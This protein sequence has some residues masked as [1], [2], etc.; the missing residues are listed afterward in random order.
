VAHRRAPACSSTAASTRRSP[1]TTPW[2]RCR[3]AWSSSELIATVEDDL[4]ETQKFR[5]VVFAHQDGDQVVV[6]L[7]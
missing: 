5:A 6:S 2:S 1:P 3:R 4:G 7:F